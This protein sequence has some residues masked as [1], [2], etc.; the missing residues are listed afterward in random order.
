MPPLR[1]RDG[2]RALPG[3]A[4]PLLR[5]EVRELRRD[6]GPGRLQEPGAGPWVQEEGRGRMI[7]H[8]IVF[9]LVSIPLTAAIPVCYPAL[10]FPFRNGGGLRCPGITCSH[11][12]WGTPADP[13]RS[14]SVAPPRWSRFP[15]SGSFSS[16]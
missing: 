16:F 11:S 2:I 8:L 12:A 5:V 1:R 3:Y 10:S 14:G 15:C 13:G 4:D 7:A 9:L 6:R